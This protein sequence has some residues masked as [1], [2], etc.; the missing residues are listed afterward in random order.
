MR[1]AIKAATI[2]AALFVP[3]LAQ[4]S[5]IASSNFSTGVDGWAVGEF[6][7]PSGTSAATW[8]SA[9]GWITTS[10]Q[11]GWNA[12]VAPSTYLGNQSGAF[13]GTISFLLADNLND[14]LPYAA[15]AL[16]SGST[17]LYALSTLIPSTSQSSLTSYSFTLTGANFG[18]NVNG[19]GPAV[20]DAQLLAVLSNLDRLAINA[21]WRTGSDFVTLDDV[22]LTGM[23]QGGVPEPAAW[24]MM[25][26]GF[27][28][29][30]GAMRRRATLQL[31]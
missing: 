6:T 8:D 2:A 7:G 14:N 26:A 27:G 12:F 25:L 21:D 28:L 19:S 15:V 13:G 1:S 29:V 20:T 31:A 5:V 11:Y 18:T 22:V 17:V 16:H 24:A 10:D 9:N 4:A 30:G 23:R 3:A